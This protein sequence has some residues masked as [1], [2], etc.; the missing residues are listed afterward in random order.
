[1]TAS[2]FLRSIAESLV[3]NKEAIHIEEKQ[4]ELGT[5]ISLRVDPSD[6]G[7]IIGRGGKTIDSLR[8]VMRVFGSKSG[9]RI[10]LR[11]IEDAPAPV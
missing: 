10:N 2:I 11:M 6:M 8:T 9:A 3:S 7:M 5:L 4:D 1:M